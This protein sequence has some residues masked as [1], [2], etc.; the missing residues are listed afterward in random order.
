MDFIFQNHFEQNIIDWIYLS[1]KKWCKWLSNEGSNRGKAG[2][3][4]SSNKHVQNVISE[5]FCEQNLI[6]D[7]FLKRHIYKFFS[8]KS[9]IYKKVFAKTRPWGSNWSLRQI[10][11]FANNLS[12]RNHEKTM[13]LPDQHTTFRRLN[14]QLV[15]WY[16]EVPR[17]F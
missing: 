4:Q 16:E 5:I 8:G 11:S 14:A 13:F 1:Y 15:Q 7:F 2:F 3:S 9:H 12:R 6:S 10:W 17:N